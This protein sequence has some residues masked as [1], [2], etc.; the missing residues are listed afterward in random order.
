ME[1]SAEKLQAEYYERTAA[2]YDEMHNS[3]GDHE[4]N[5]ALAY[6]AMMSKDL[7]LTSFL[8]VG[9]GTGRGVKFLWNRGFEAHGV[10]PVPALIR[11]A[12]S[13]GVP[14]GLIVEG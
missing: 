14:E 9:A 7:G 1:N 3:G 13:T 6:I 5:L 2:Y 11:Q 10:E 4:H 12:E 8:D